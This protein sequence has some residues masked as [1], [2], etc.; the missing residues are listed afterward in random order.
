M[1]TRTFSMRGW[2]LW[3]AGFLAFPIAGVAGIAAAGRVD[4][5]GAALLGGAVSGAV[6][7]LGQTLVSRFQLDWRRW[8]PATALG[9][10]VGLAVGAAAVGYG[11]SLSD[12]ALMGAV[13]GVALGIAQ[14]AA[15]PP[16]TR[17]RYLWALA[18]P[19]LWAL[20]WSVTTLIGYEVDKQVPIYGASG[21]LAFTAL[22]GLLILQLL[23]APLKGPTAPAASSVAGR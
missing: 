7:G 23:P 8:V 20:G 13:T 18:M 22:S 2:A 15:L 1:K 4:A 9:M 6:L 10:G 21:A 16:G 19:V 17:N 5:A 11:T 14:T 3:T 12:L